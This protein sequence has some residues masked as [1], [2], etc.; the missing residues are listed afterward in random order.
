MANLGSINE[1]SNR[2]RT[3]PNRSKELKFYD[4]RFLV[5][6]VIKTYRGIGSPCERN[7]LMQEGYLCLWEIIN[8][9]TPHN[10][11]EFRAMAITKI[12]NRLR[13]CRRY[14]NKIRRL[15]P[16]LKAQAVSARQSLYVEQYA[17]TCGKSLETLIS[18]L[19]PKQQDSITKLFGIQGGE[20]SAREIAI[21]ES[22]CPRAIWGR[23]NRGI[24]K[25]R[26][27]LNLQSLAS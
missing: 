2:F 25:L 5:H 19:S 14:Q 11:G 10:D 18:D 15:L 20:M 27:N 24:K 4:H 12:K 9:N 13:T 3:N 1:H 23:C 16:R 7:D 26:Q 17:E 21:Q 6:Q 22:K 8:L